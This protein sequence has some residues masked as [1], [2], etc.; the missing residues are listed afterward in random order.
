LDYQCSAPPSC[1]QTS[2]IRE[3]VIIRAKATNRYKFHTG[4]SKLRAS[5]PASSR[6]PLAQIRVINL[7]PMLR[8]S[9]GIS[10]KSVEDRLKV[11]LF[12]IFPCVQPAFMNATAVPREA[13]YGRTSQV[14]GPTCTCPCLKDLRRL[15]R[16]TR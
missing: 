3:K 13:S 4:L 11:G 14:I 6:P 10:T 7:F 12:T 15:C 8:A 16:C 9:L 5:S 1:R 2:G